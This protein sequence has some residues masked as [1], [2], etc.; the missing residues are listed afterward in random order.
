MG[1]KQLLNYKLDEALEC[2]QS[3][4]PQ[5]KNSCWALTQLGQAMVAKENF[6]KVS[7]ALVTIRHSNVGL[8]KLTY[9]SV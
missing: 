1:Y 6:K 7:I 5:Y 8:L 9:T 3:L 2:I 4:P